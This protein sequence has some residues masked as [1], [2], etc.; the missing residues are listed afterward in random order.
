MPQIRR[1]HMATELAAPDG[2]AVQVMGNPIAL[3]GKPAHMRN[4]F[5]ARLG[6]NTAEADCAT[7]TRA[8]GR[9]GSTSWCARWLLYAQANHD[10]ALKAMSAA[11]DAEDKTEKH[12]VTPGVPTP[13][14][15]FYGAMLLDHGMPKEALVAFE[16]TLKKEPNRLGTL[17]GAARAAAKSGDIAKSRQ[18][19]A[20]IAALA[21]A[22]A[23]IR[24]EITEARAA[25][26]KSL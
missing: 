6:A 21:D 24:P 10:E 17:S 26:A 11:A 19:Y 16:A 8:Q 13:A 5:R 20:R 2:R 23:P 12:V 9:Q 14:R 22:A 4:V 1:R 18:Y 25:L 15:E 3:A 7:R